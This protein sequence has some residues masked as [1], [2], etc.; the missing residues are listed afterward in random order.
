MAV[1]NPKEFIQQTLSMAISFPSAATDSLVAAVEVSEIEFDRNFEE[2]GFFG[3]PWAPNSPMT[4]ANKGHSKILTGKTGN[5]RKSKQGVRIG[6]T[7]KGRI[8]YS[9]KSKRGDVDYAP[10]MQNGFV[11]SN[12]SW[13]RGAAVPSRK[14][15]GKSKKLDARVMVSMHKIIGLALN[16]NYVKGR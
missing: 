5:L 3:E 15:V 4:I 12:K 9:Y 1:Y 2:Q 14:I 11:T 10:L 8:T 13:G 6:T 16:R 7:N